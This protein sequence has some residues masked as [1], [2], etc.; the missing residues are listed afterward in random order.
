MIFHSFIQRHQCQILFWALGIF[1]VKRPKFQPTGSSHSKENTQTI[2]DMDKNQNMLETRSA[3]E[4]ALRSTQA[5]GDLI[6]MNQS[7]PL[8]ILVK[9]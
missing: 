6:Y 8:D 1:K 9:T 7:R 4:R 3:K 2:T 5:G